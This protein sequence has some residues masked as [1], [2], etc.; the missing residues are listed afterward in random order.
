MTAHPT[1]IFVP[2]QAAYDRLHVMSMMDKLSYHLPGHVFRHS[3]LCYTTYPE[4]PWTYTPGNIAISNA[5][6]KMVLFC[7]SISTV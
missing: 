4:P 3:A 2:T 5:N 1:S 6:V 7:I